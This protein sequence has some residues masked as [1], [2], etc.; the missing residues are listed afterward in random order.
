MDSP[1]KLTQ[2]SRLV[3]PSYRCVSILAKVPTCSAFR[4]SLVVGMAFSSR[5]PGAVTVL[6]CLLYLCNDVKAQ[7]ETEK[8][9]NFGDTVQILGAVGH[10]SYQAHVYISSN[11]YRWREQIKTFKMA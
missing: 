1:Y 10:L 5:W 7:N 8:L 4:S 2:N 9:P 11:M 3:E 6:T